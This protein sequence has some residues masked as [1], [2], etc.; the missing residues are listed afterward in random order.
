MGRI[1]FGKFG[2]D[3]PEQI[4]EKFYAAGPEGNP[5]YGGIK[6]GDYVFP[7]FNSKINAL[8]KVRGYGEKP[9]RIH[10]EDNWVVFFDEVYKFEEPVSVQKFIKYPYFEY[11]INLLNKISRPTMGCG[12]FEIKLSPDAPDNPTLYN[13][14][15]ER[16]IFITLE[17]TTIDAKENDINIIINHETQIV[18]IK[19]YQNGAWRPYFPLQNLYNEKNPIKYSLNQLLKYAQEDIAPN[20]EKYIKSVLSELEDKGYFIV[21][22]P[23]QLYENILVGR[24]KTPRTSSVNDVSNPREGEDLQHDDVEEYWEELE[25]YKKYADLLE[26]NPNLILYGPPGTGKTYATKKIIECFETKRTG[27]Y[28]KFDTVVKEER[29]KFVTFHQS[30]SYEEFIEGIRPQLNNEDNTDLKYKIEDG[31]LKEFVE[32]A[33]TQLLK[34]DIHSDDIQLIRDSSKVWKVSLGHRSSDDVYNE[35]KK[36]KVIAVGWLRDQDLTNFSYEDIFTSLNKERSDDEPEPFQDASSLDNFVNQMSIGDIVL[37]YDGPTTIRD[38]AIVKGDY[39]YNK[40]MIYP[41]TREVAWLKEFEEPVDIFEL[42]GRKKLTLKT[43]YELPRISISDILKLVHVEDK[44]KQHVSSNDIKPYYLIIDEINRGNISKI[45]GELITLIE[46]DK[47]NCVSVT[48]PYSKKSFTIPENLYII[49]TMN[50]ADRSIAMLDA[51]LRRRFVFIEVEPD[52]TIFIK[53]YLN[54]SSRIN[55]SIELDKLLDA[56]NKKILKHL[57]RDHRIG[58]SYFMD[59]I[60]LEDFYK[61]WYYKILPLL[62]EYFYQDFETIKEIIGSKFLDE[63]GNIQYLSIK[64]NNSQYSEFEQAIMAIY[65]E[66]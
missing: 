58:H 49:G 66:K 31:I 46:K 10:K 47:R 33:S 23:I 39:K 37:I 20:K 54:I 18:G 21:D 64:P 30:Y 53:P 17:N 44:E 29:V 16:K 5:W 50:T 45:F 48:L 15:N 42:N 38:I 9:N 61:T 6:P 56:L 40:K 59:I 11:D 65:T 43:V 19:I 57:D 34:A 62:M 60:T 36:N 63:Y 41:H 3:K 4:E 1:F 52:P 35:C 25:E 26:F 22:N 28:V 13:F 32:S 7:I 12:F 27:K 8:W 14:Q 24:R 2:K 51:A 55:N